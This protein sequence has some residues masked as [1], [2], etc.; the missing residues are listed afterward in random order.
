M[1]NFTFSRM[2]LGPKVHPVRR[3]S[4]P[5]QWGQSDGLSARAK[6]TMRGTP[7]A[8]RERKETTHYDAH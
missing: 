6:N 7:A 2:F 3:P 1:Q 4:G 8:P 5:V